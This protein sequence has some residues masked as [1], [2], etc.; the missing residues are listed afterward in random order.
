MQLQ[1]DRIPESFSFEFCH[2]TRSG[3]ITSQQ[4]EV[5][6]ERGGATRANALKSAQGK[7]VHMIPAGTLLFAF[8]AALFLSVLP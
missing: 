7:K 6:V 1:L 4:F 5:L 2:T 3:I 8:D